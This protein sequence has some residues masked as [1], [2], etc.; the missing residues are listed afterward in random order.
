MK[1]NPNNLKDIQKYYGGTYI[2]V[3]EVDPHRVF[4]I[5][6]MNSQGLQLRDP[7]NGELGFISFEGGFEYEIKS[8]LAARKQ[9]FQC[10]QTAY[11]IQR[12]PARMWRKGICSENT[13]LYSFNSEGNL[14]QVGIDAVLLNALLAWQP[15]E[16]ESLTNKLPSTG[17]ALSSQ[18][19][20]CP[21]KSQLFLWDHVVGKV[22]KRTQ[23][24]FVPKEL[25][26][27]KLPTAAS[28]MKVM[29]V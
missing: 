4:C 23:E 3:P 27:L 13:I 24:L 6:D 22:A 17:V 9:W 1:A 16:I 18:Y 14:R 15:T 11:L 20:F 28:K 5:D 25:Q 7:M 29:Y 10:N 19:A 21:V 8:P 26:E 12:I 2:T